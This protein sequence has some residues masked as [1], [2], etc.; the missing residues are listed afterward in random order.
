MAIVSRYAD[1]NGLRL[2]YAVSGEGN[3]RL[4]LFAH[5]FPQFWYAWK[6]LLAEFGRDFLAVAPDLRGYNLSDKPAGAEHYTSR[7]LVA[8]LRAL[9]AH[10][11]H[12]RFTLVGHDWG[13][14]VAWGLAIAHP[15]LLEHL[16][17]INSP[18]PAIF[19]RELRENRA[20]QRASLYMRRFR[21]PS[22]EG[23]LA[24]DNFRRL[25]AALLDDGLARG[26]FTPADADAYLAAWAQPG[27][28][29]GGLNYYRAMRLAPPTTAPA[30]DQP[31]FIDDLPPLDPAEADDPADLSA[32]PARPRDPAAFT[33]RVPTL[34]IWGER[35]TALL[36]GNLDGLTNY[37]PD[38]TIRRIPDAGHW[39]IHEQPALVIRHIREFVQSGNA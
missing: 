37:I 7:H 16:I 1:V 6:D 39:V 22:A 36:P 10:L 2:H 29:T 38:L 23:W 32:R 27:A 4:I 19:E 24:E 30:T 26:Y 18:H 33:V 11:G 15:E 28:L 5:G 31:A 20:Q 25:G 17:I 12:E 8:D 14:A 13:G 34:V 35:D 3:E 21:Q 9:A